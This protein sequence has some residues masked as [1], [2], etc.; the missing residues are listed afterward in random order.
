MDAMI[1]ILI[2]IGVGAY[3]WSEYGKEW[4]RKFWLWLAERNPYY[5]VAKDVSLTS[6]AM[7]KYVKEA[8]IKK[9]MELEAQVRSLESTLS[10]I[11][12]KMAASKKFDEEV[13]KQEDDKINE[14]LSIPALLKPT[15]ED[16]PIKVYD[17]DGVF[18][19]YL[20]SVR[21][22][23]SEAYIL[24]RTP[25]NK[26][27]IFGPDALDN[28]LLNEQTFVD[29]VKSGVLMIAYDRYNNKVSPQYVR[30]TV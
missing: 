23:F 30:V 24:V 8:M 29:Q 6:P 21:G 2:L 16:A 20:D 3:F 10:Q 1:P 7:K 17:A 18:R 11:Q 26:L 15:A 25:D 22:T 27:L 28:L 9:M 13:K 14:V 12:D 4:K 19:G 5:K